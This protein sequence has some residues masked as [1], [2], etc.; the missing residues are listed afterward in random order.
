[1]SKEDLLAK[2]KSI[3]IP[4][5]FEVLVAE[6]ILEKK[7]L[8]YKILDMKRLPDHAKDKIIGISSNGKVKFSKPTKSAQ[9][10][11]DKLSK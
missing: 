8:G 1:M 7:G 10:L 9:E 4:I 6:G 5:D 2:A 3:A 11:V